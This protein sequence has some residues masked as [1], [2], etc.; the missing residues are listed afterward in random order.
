MATQQPTTPTAP[1]A[2][3]AGQL[4]EVVLKTPEHGAGYLYPAVATG[5]P[6]A[7]FGFGFSVAMLSIANARLVSPLAIGMF[8]PVA[9]VTGG[10][11]MFTGG[12]AEFRRDNLFG[13][14]F[15]VAYACFLI[16]TP[17]ILR[18]FSPA[19]I[20]A[21][22]TD[23]FGDAFGAYLILWAIFTAMLTV[24]AYH[25]NMPAFIAFA[26]LVVVYALLAWDN[27]VQ[28]T[29]TTL[30]KTAG[31]VGLVDSAAAWYLG[32]AIVLNATVGRDLLP[33]FPHRSREE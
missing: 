1:R 14:T 23:S 5:V 20:K 33:L 30:Q 25:I 18:F 31:W 11:A 10:L 19:I 15:G 27:I 21:A 6:L 16:T 22:G 32:A 17:L 29:G 13:G 8:V 12:V 3:G 26:L 24:G 7:V 2:D 4:A 9:L 28:P